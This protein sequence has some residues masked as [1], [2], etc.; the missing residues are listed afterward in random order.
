[1]VHNTKMTTENDQPALTADDI[2]SALALI[3]YAAAKGTY[4]GWDVM[5]AALTVRSRLKT[6]TDAVDA[7]QAAAQEEQPS[8]PQTPK[9]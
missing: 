4:C 2:K 6:F 7:H 8:E 1:M 3:D 9:E 5:A